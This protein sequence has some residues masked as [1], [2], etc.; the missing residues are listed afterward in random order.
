MAFRAELRPLSPG[1]VGDVALR[2][3]LGLGC[4]PIG[5]LYTPVADDDAVATVRAALDD[6]V[7]FFDTAPHYGAGESERRLGLALQGV[8]RDDYVIA[9]KVGRRIVDAAGDPVAGSASGHDTVADLSRD[10]VLR[11][12]EAS[13]ARL[14]TDRIDLLHLHDPLD[15]DAGLAGAMTALVE[16]RDQGVVR[17]IG[18]GMGRLAPLIR[19]AAEAPVDVIMEAGRLTLLDRTAEDELLPLTASRGIGVIAAGVYNTGILVA[20]QTAPYY[21]YKPAPPE[22]VARALALQDACRAHGVE[23]ATAAARFPLRHGAEGVVIGA[24]TPTEVAA[25]VHGHDVRIPDALWSELDRIAAPG[26]AVS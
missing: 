7:R 22:L 13:L 10:G 19:F 23:L 18:V 25:F 3:D 20:P 24:R 9:T 5:N 6:G 12:L 21:E 16:L 17:A 15:V 2:D 26:T 4:A 11:S 1:P 14:R 8:P